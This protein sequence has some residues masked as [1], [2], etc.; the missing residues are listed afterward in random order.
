MIAIGFFLLCVV[1]LMMVFDR[2]F[3]GDVPEWYAAIG[4]ISFAGG[5][6]SIAA[7]VAMVLWRVMP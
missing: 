4:V 1:A 5:V 2:G 6:L 7:G 3:S